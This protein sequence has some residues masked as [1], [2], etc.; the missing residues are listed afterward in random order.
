MGILFKRY[1][2]TPYVYECAECGIHLASSSSTISKGFNG[3]L[4]KAYLFSRIVNVSEGPSESR[5]LLTGSH[6]VCDV[7]CNGCNT[8]L[9]WKYVHA[10]D[11]EQKYKIGSYVLEKTLIMLTMQSF[12]PDLVRDDRGTNKTIPVRIQS[13]ECESPLHASRHGPDI[14]NV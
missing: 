10:E 11:P 3:S 2:D 8:L 13:S 9:G 6:V 12:V 14:V 5:A 4:G 7:F 1:L